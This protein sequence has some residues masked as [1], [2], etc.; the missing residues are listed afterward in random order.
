MTKQL[1]EI[2]VDFTTR[3]IVSSNIEQATLQKLEINKDISL[4]GLIIILEKQQ[5]LRK[6]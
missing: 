6:S 2:Q 5:I 3:A 1:I 4:N